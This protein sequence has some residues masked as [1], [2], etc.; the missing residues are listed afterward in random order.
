MQEFVSCLTR[1]NLFWLAF[2]ANALQRKGRCVYKGLK[3]VGNVQAVLLLEKK[4][5]DR[6]FEVF[7]AWEFV[8]TVCS[9]V[10]VG[11]EAGFCL[12][13]LVDVAYCGVCVQ[14]IECKIQNVK[15]L[16]FNRKLC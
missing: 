16:N 11:C 2:S 10:R 14:L 15:H 7:I 8:L 4:Q 1:C 5:V 12:E 3:R 13:L 9:V 6:L